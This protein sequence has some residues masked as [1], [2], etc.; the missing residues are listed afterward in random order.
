MSES[1]GINNTI[2]D[3][4]SNALDNKINNC[5]TLLPSSTGK[6]AYDLA[7]DY[8][9]VG[10]ES[11]WLDTLQGLSAY[12]VAVSN[13]Y[14]GT[15]TE[16]L[17]YIKGK[18]AYELSVDNGFIGNEKEWL[19]GIINDTELMNNL[20]ID[21]L[22]IAKA[23]NGDEN[24]TVVTRTGETYPSAKKAISEGIKSLFENGGLPA[25]PFKTKALMSASLLVDGVYAMVTEDTVSNGLYVKTAGAWVKSGYD[26]VSTS[27]EYALATE[28]KLVGEV[29]YKKL[30]GLV[31]VFTD[32]NDVSRVASST[33]SG[34]LKLYGGA[35]SKPL[36]AGANISI[37]EGTQSITISSGDTVYIAPTEFVLCLVTGQ[38]N[39][40][41][42]GGD[43]SLAPIVPDLVCRAWDFI[44][45]T[46][47]DINVQS[48]F[49]TVVK[50]T[51]VPAM[52]LEFYK[53][54]G[55]GLIVVNAAEGSS[56]IAAEAT[57]ANGKG[58]WDIGGNLRGRAVSAYNGCKAYLDANNICYQNGFITN[59]HG[60]QDGQQI[61]AGISTKAQ[62]LR[63][64]N[65]L[66]DY[67]HT[68]LGSKLPFIISRTAYRDSDLQGY[69]DMRALQ[70]ELTHT[71]PNT[72]MGYTG[73]YKFFERGFVTDGVHFNQEGKNIL[74]SAMGK[75]A[76]K[77][78]TG[79]N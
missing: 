68:E 10:T 27:K 75:I 6:S 54:T 39:A 47:Q 70:M 72:Y 56:A 19:S 58:H 25:V 1:N 7:V 32:S 59:I 69:K 35:T 43:A 76:S 30:E 9:Y 3:A 48:A 24:T 17:K 53:Q 49:T 45:N 78:S 63:A 51:H 16:W 5:N 26:P 13:G 14:K 67:L 8:G 11:T 18:S 60:E 46:L 41:F 42:P 36:V 33:V 2:Y 38:S 28:K 22:T 52:A 12:E 50:Q 21:L 20:N 77:L 74:G 66:I 15:K 29:Y 57:P 62:T 40:M 55:M 23:A 44:T 65:D 37:L 79:I 64:Y 73:A 31:E 4:V 71:K 34:D 61:S